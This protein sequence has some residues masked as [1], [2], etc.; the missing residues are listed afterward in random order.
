M[1]P[2]SQTPTTWWSVR[3]RATGTLDG[4]P[5]HVSGAESLVA[6]GMIEQTV[7]GLSLIHI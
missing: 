4:A 7:A 1:S 6:P 5:Y 3:M 2:S